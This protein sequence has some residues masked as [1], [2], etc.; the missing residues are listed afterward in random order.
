MAMRITTKMMQNTSLRNL[1]TNKALEEKLTNQLSTGMK[2][3]RPSDDPVIAIRS[4]RLNASLDKVKQYYEKNASDAKNWL[5]ITES[6]IRTVNTI[7]ETDVKQNIVNAKSSY[8][9]ADQRKDI[10][11]ALKDKIGEIYSVGNA[12]SA[13]RTVFTGYRTDMPLA[14]KEDKIEKYT[15]TQQL[16]NLDIDKYTFVSTGMLKNINEGN[17]NKLDENQYKVSTNDI[18]RIRLA[19]ADIDLEEGTAAKTK[20]G[21]TTSYGAYINVGYMKGVTTTIDGANLVGTSF[22]A[23]ANIDMSGYRDKAIIKIN[24]LVAGN[25]VDF[26][27]YTVV[28]GT[29]GN[30][31][32]DPSKQNEIT[33]AKGTTVS[34]S[35]YNVSFTEDGKIEVT[36]L[37]QNGEIQPQESVRVGYDKVAGSNGKTEVKFD[38]KYLTSLKVDNFYPSSTSDAAYESV[39]NN[40]NQMTYLA[41]TGELLLGKDIQKRLSE[42]S[43]DTE[44]RVTYDKS[45]WNKNDLDPIHYFYTE[46]K[47]TDNTDRMLKYNENFLVDPTA[48][49]KQIIEYDVGNNQ[50]LRVNTTADEFLNHDMGRD[51]EEVITMLEEYGVL[52]ECYNTIDSMIKSEKY[53][54][55]DLTKL[56]QELDAIEKARTMVG[57]KITN[58]CDELLENCELYLKRGQTAETNCGNRGSRLELIK[59]RLNVQETSFEELVSDNDDA[60]YAELAIQMKSIQMTYQA[61]L[62][63]ISY[64]LQTSLLDFIR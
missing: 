30:V 36:R 29:N 50:S 61:A 55:E 20:Y 34:I 31:E 18:Y 45:N 21:S 49:G 10:I 19:Y 35:G 25:A 14:F 44:L 2:I 51:A 48:S 60:D 64:V 16:T 7:L 59:N 6:G 47:A 53:V 32:F 5:E 12:D 62:S 43:N 1:N 58:R 24:D 56:Q 63:S 38:D 23:Y 3:D 33:L 54:G 15:I 9:T 41:D 28:D 8:K 42:L 46:K 27:G 52:D 26:T 37:K 11:K 4:L 57:D 22:A 39:L 13:G 40:P 17:F